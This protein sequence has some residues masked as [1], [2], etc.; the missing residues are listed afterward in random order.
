MCRNAALCAR[1]VQLLLINYAGG[2][3]EDAD[4]DIQPITRVDFVPAKVFRSRSMNTPTGA[5]ISVESLPA[6]PPR[7]RKSDFGSRKIIIL[8]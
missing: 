1:H 6:F 4:V 7:M 2:V 3:A 8:P 5:L